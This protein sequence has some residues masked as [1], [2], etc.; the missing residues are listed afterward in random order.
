LQDFLWAIK[1]W[2]KKFSKFFKKIAKCFGA[3]PKFLI[4]AL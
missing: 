4:F 2:R 3:K 1:K